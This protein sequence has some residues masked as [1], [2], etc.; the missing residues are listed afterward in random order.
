MVDLVLLVLLIAAVSSEAVAFDNLRSYFNVLNFKP[1]N[2]TFCMGF[3]FGVVALLVISYNANINDPESL[4]QWVKLYVIASS[5]FIMA[6]GANKI[7]NW[8]YG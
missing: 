3:W 4:R 7:D 6:V 2:C 5:P 8:M 1:F